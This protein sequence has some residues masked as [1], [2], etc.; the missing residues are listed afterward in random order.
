M[1]WVNGFTPTGPGSDCSGSRWLTGDSG[2]SGTKRQPLFL[3]LGPGDWLPNNVFMLELSL[4]LAVL[5]TAARGQ[6]LACLK[7]G[8]RYLSRTATGSCNR[9]SSCPLEG[10]QGCNVYAAGR[11]CFRAGL[12]AGQRWIAGMFGAQPRQYFT[13]PTAAL[14]P[15]SS[16]TAAT[17]PQRAQQWVTRGRE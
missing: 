8:A 13:G 15:C 1:V 14:Q 16:D 6:L 3:K 4:S 7:P 12:G 11:L 9:C 2:C 5:L 17:P 10:R